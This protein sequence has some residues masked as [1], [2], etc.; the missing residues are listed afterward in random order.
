RLGSEIATHR[1]RIEFNRQRADELTELIERARRDITDAEKKREQHAA[2]IAQTN[3]S[4]AEIDRHLREQEAELTQL[5]GLSGEIQKHRAN[6]GTR[7][8]ELQLAL[9]KSESR[10]SA[11]EEELSGTKT[12]REL[13]RAQIEQ[14]AGEIQTLTEARENLVREIAVSLQASHREGI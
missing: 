1:S 4:I 9:S 2:E 10:V 8:Q 3:D 7:L 14:L 11:I 5:A 12:R 13:T 6:R